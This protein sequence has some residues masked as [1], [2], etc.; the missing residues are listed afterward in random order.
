MLN[1]LAPWVKRWRPENRIDFGKPLTRVNGILRVCCTE[2]S[3]LQV[4]RNDKGEPVEFGE[5]TYAR[6]CKECGR[7]HYTMI[8]EPG[9]YNTRNA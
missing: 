9:V 8:A 6:E 3:N 5:G 1:R 4:I 7:K 2:D